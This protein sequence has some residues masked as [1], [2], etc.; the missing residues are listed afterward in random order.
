MFSSDESAF[1][2]ACFNSSVCVIFRFCVSKYCLV[3]YAR[4]PVYPFYSPVRKNFNLWLW[5]LIR[6]KS[7]TTAKAGVTA[8]P[9]SVAWI[10][11]CHYNIS[12]FIAFIASNFFHL[13]F[14]LKL[15]RFFV[16]GIFRSRM[17]Y[18]KLLPLR[19]KPEQ[20]LHLHKFYNLLHCYC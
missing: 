11:S 7:F 2:I 4:L 9:P 6:P 8:N 3:I 15:P 10:Y 5:W 12:Q 20:F 13:K 17:I 1:A 16:L 19:I 18:Y 14:L